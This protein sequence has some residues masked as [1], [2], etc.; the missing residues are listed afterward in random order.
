MINSTHRKNGVLFPTAIIPNGT[1]IPQGNSP[2]QTTARGWILAK[3]I[4]RKPFDFVEK[5]RIQCF[6]LGL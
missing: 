5:V 1:K 3:L 2:V 6:K 4:V